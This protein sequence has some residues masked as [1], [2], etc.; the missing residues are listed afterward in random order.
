M[1]LKK[2]KKKNDTPIQFLSLAFKAILHL[3]LLTCTRRACPVWSGGFQ[4]LWFHLNPPLPSL[5]FSSL[6]SWNILG[7]VLF[8][9]LLN[10][11]LCL[12]DS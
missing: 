12:E 2:K 1:V 9:G 4:P 5:S 11:F 7:S 10:S 3:G 8:W 6:S